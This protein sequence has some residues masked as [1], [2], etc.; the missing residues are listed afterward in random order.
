MRARGGW[1][2]D[3]PA[4]LQRSTTRPWAAAKPDSNAPPEWLRRPYTRT[5]SKDLRTVEQLQVSFE[6]VRRQ[7]KCIC[8]T[9]GGINVATASASASSSSP[10]VLPP[11]VRS[12]V[13]QLVSQLKAVKQELLPHLTRMLGAL[14]LPIDATATASSTSPQQDRFAADEKWLE[15]L[16]RGDRGGRAAAAATAASRQ[17]DAS[18]RSAYALRKEYLQALWLARRVW[19]W[20][21]CLA[22]ASLD[23]ELLSGSISM[24]TEIFFGCPF[25]SPDEDTQDWKELFRVVFDSCYSKNSEITE[26]E[27]YAAV[28]A[29]T[30]AVHR[31]ACEIR[32]FLGF[33][34]GSGAKNFSAG[35]SP[36]A[37][38]R[39]DPQ[40]ASID[41]ATH[42]PAFASTSTDTSLWTRDAFWI[43]AIAL[44]YSIVVRD[45]TAAARLLATLENASQLV[46][47]H[48]VDNEDDVAVEGECTRVSCHWHM[49]AAIAFVRRVAKLLLDEDYIAL[50]RVWRREGF[51]ETADTAQAV[52]N[53]GSELRA[54]VDETASCCSSSTPLALL[55]PEARI[56]VL[57]T[58]L[59]DEHVVRR[60][61]TEQ[62]VGQAFRPI[63]PVPR[64]ATTRKE[65]NAANPNRLCCAILKAP[66]AMANVGDS[67]SKAGSDNG[68]VHVVQRTSAACLCDALWIAALGD[69]GG[70]WPLPGLLLQ[71]A[72]G[73]K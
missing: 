19:A 64:L 11:G 59:L 36:D 46:C 70:D 6:D 37:H 16:S 56:L 12:S 21:I 22:S 27:L 49:R 63:E 39:V 14:S 44:C 35:R 54:Q 9:H 58:R 65:N 71:A 24:S 43:H 48:T 32:A 30:S 15:E 1:S 2:N 67:T 57:L 52:S 7:W 34:G 18:D 25:A 4:N 31:E 72:F 10:V 29:S 20:S 53:A 40:A 23:L 33:A 38:G 60:R 5:I 68:V 3:H 69:M 61:W 42:P 50:Q 13:D 45:E 8:D 26:Q 41:E 62:G 17:G 66:Q 73:G 47:M 55:F 28:S 51:F